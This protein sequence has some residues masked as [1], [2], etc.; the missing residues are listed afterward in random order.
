MC[1]FPKNK[2]ITYSRKIEKEMNCDHILQID[3][4]QLL[5]HSIL[6]ADIICESKCHT[7]IDSFT[8]YFFAIVRNP[9][10]II[11]MVLAVKAFPE[12]VWS[13]GVI[14]MLIMHLN[15]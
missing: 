9:V 14:Q 11:E 7:I 3:Q 4:I 15:C 5:F 2:Y 13:V 8:F 6:F 12:L 1:P 10:L